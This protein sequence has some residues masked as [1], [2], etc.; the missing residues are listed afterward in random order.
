MVTRQPLLDFVLQFNYNVAQFCY[1]NK[2][3]VRYETLKEALGRTNWN[4]AYQLYCY[5]IGLYQCSDSQMFEII[6][7]IIRCIEMIRWE[8]R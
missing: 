6:K 8:C 4:N 3:F 5:A 2:S 1:F 7:E